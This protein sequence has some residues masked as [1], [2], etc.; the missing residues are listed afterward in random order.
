MFPGGPCPR[1]LGAFAYRVVKPLCKRNRSGPNIF[2]LQ[3]GRKKKKI[4]FQYCTRVIFRVI[5]RIPFDRGSAVTERRSR[6]RIDSENRNSRPAFSGAY[7]ADRC[8]R[9][10]GVTVSP[11]SRRASNDDDEWKTGAR[12]AARLFNA[13]GTRVSGSPKFTSER[14]ERFVFSVFLFFFCFSRLPFDRGRFIGRF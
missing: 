9:R 12:F 14:E 10:V 5:R 8:C 13:G 3:R 2:P 4:K 6:D 1:I 7:P 11:A